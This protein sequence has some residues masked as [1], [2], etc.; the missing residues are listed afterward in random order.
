MSPVPLL[1]LGQSPFYGGFG[2]GRVTHDDVLTTGPR[3]VR[4]R[5]ATRW[6]RLRAAAR[7]DALIDDDGKVL[8]HE[9]VA[10]HH[11]CGTTTFSSRGLGVDDLPQKEPICGTCEGRAI[12][13]GHGSELVTVEDGVKLLFTP[14]IDPPKVCPGSGKINQHLWVE[15]PGSR[16]VGLCVPCGQTVP[17]RAGGGS[18]WYGS[19]WYG[20]QVHE[21][22]DDLVDPC[23]AHGWTSLVLVRGTYGMGVTCR[24][25]LPRREM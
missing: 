3:Y 9:Y 25:R 11:W 21:P 6:H 7:H 16:S 23:M 2:A 18:P 15:I 1:P 13:A 20:P 17:T 22:G 19:N 4:S 12:G 8:R 24:C 10:W 5:Q 14:H